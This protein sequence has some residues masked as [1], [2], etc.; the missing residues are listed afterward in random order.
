M[1]WE[2]VLHISASVLKLYLSRPCLC[3]LF[4]CCYC[5]F[6]VVVVGGGGKTV[7]GADCWI[8]LP[9]L[10]WA[11]CW[12]GGAKECCTA[13]CWCC[14]CH[15][16]CQHIHLHTITLIDIE[17]LMNRCNAFSTTFSIQC[18]TSVSYFDYFSQK[19]KQWMGESEREGVIVIADDV[20]G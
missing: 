6:V 10:R 2:T 19:Q 11:W 5:C 3:F 15:L 1:R 17:R 20:G 13:D 12:C 4:L 16:D 7:K 14:I 18:N 8:F 9:K